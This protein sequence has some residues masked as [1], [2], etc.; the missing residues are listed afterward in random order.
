MCIDMASR[1][2]DF[3][4]NKSVSGETAVHIVIVNGDLDSL[5]LLVG[6]CGADVHARAKGRF[7]MPED[8]KDKMKQV[9]DYEGKYHRL[10]SF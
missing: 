3:D 8:S 5:K 6:S 10:P 2:K 7:F 1:K 4:V 9:T